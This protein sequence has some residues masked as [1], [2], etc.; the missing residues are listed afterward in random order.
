M[1][2]TKKYEITLKD[3]SKIILWFIGDRLEKLMDEYGIPY[4][5]LEDDTKW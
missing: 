1:G 4:K 2:K 5:E 3:G